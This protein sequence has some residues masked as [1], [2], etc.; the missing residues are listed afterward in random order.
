MWPKKWFLFPEWWQALWKKQKKSTKKISIDRLCVYVEE[1]LPKKNLIV[2][3]DESIFFISLHQNVPIRLIYLYCFDMA[4][5]I[6]FVCLQFLIVVDDGNKCWQFKLKS[7]SIVHFKMQKKNLI[8][9][10]VFDFENKKIHQT[11]TQTDRQT[12]H[13]SLIVSL[14]KIIWKI[15]MIF[16]WWW[17]W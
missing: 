17:W 9:S 8:D 1:L 6:I 15:I 4:M 16:W 10:N 13:K 5:I 12:R 14:L 11:N 7:F 3:D 2:M